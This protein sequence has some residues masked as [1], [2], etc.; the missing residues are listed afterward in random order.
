MWK[1]FGGAPSKPLTIE[2]QLEASIVRLQ[3][4]TS[5]AIEASFSGEKAD[6]Q[7]NSS[8]HAADSFTLLPTSLSEKTHVRVFSTLRRSIGR[9]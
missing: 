8:S 1:F 7:L 9:S 4:F 3:T 6:T 2:E 5:A